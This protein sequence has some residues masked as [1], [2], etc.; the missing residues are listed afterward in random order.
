M[1]KAVAA[2]ACALGALFLTGSAAGVVRYG[3]T[4][5][6]GK[7]ATDGGAGFFA[8]L[9]DVGLTEN[10]IT[11]YWDPALPG[12]MA[13]PGLLDRT[14]PYARAAG[15]RVV[16]TVCTQAEWSTARP[17]PSARGQRTCRHDRRTPRVR[18]ATHPR[19]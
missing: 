17:P 18:N 11:I 3:V 9:N 6:A 7:Y 1:R 15:I 4:E 5:D 14:L 13:E 8:Q 10:A 12:G 19:S 2:F 16:L